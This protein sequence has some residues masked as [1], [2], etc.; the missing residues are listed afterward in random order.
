MHIPFPLKNF[1][2]LTFYSQSLNISFCVCWNQ[3]DDSKCWNLKQ[4]VYYFIKVTHT[5]TIRTIFKAESGKA[6]QRQIRYKHIY[7]Y[8]Y[9]H[10]TIHINPN[11]SARMLHSK[12]TKGSLAVCWHFIKAEFQKKKNISRHVVW[13]CAI[14]CLKEMNELEEKLAR[15]RTV[16]IFI[17]SVCD[18]R[19]WSSI[20]SKQKK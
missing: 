10:S 5:R 20:D 14:L 18:M 16:L 11:H 2:H 7:T 6:K 12:R 9:K 15:Q 4:E 1:Y 19:V 13:A 17:W 8:T 3:N